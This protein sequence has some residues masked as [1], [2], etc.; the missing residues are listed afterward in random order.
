MKYGI[1]FIICLVW[2]IAACEEKV[3][4]DWSDLEPRLV[5]DGI[6]TN[7]PFGNYIRILFSDSLTSSYTNWGNEIL[8]PPGVKNA[9]VI[10]SD[11]MGNKDTLKQSSNY[12]YVYDY[13]TDGEP[14]II[15]SFLI[16]EGYYPIESIKG[17]P[18]HT[19]YLEIKFMNREY[20]ASAFMYDVPE[21]DTI[22]FGKVYDPVKYEY[23]Y[24]PLISFPVMKDSY[25]NYMF[26]FNYVPGFYPIDST[27]ITYLGS[28]FELDMTLLNGEFLD[29]YVN[30]L[31]VL[32][33]Y[34][35]SYWLNGYTW[36]EPNQLIGIAML[37]ISPEGYSF[38]DALTKQIERFD[39]VF[40]P[41]P[42]TPVGNISG[43]AFGY[44]GASAVSRIQG[45]VPEE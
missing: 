35:G 8:T 32:Q 40:N 28:T 37:S 14:N 21:M 42:T 12:E 45:R 31:D 23:Y 25:N 29:S 39:G 34:S 2:I 36:L 10:I 26:L 22:Y 1:I 38:Y 3:D 13:M 15:D 6:I 16:E 7:E 30:G 20:H 5:V 4:F 24:P 18:G 9:L 43:G 44:F 19:Y 33:G 27:G 11:D 17:L 41:A